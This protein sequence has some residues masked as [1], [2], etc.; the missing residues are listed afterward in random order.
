MRPHRQQKRSHAHVAVVSRPM[1]QLRMTHVVTRR[2]L[3]TL[4]IVGVLVCVHLARGGCTRSTDHGRKP[5][6]PI[7]TPQQRSHT[8]DSQRQRL[9]VPSR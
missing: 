3:H 4:A 8:D 9:Q 7:N 6:E 1:W 5:A 2:V